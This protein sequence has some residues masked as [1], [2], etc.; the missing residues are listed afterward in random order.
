MRLYGQ[1]SELRLSL[2]GTAAGTPFTRQTLKALIE[3]FHRTHE[4]KRG[5]SDR[6]LVTCIH[7]L[8]VIAIGRNKKESLLQM[9][10]DTQDA[11]QALKRQRDVY[12]RE[13][14]GFVKTPCFR[15]ESLRFGN[16]IRGPAVIEE[17][18]ATIIIPPKTEVRVDKFGNYEGKL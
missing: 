7:N 16:V 11:S 2:S 17:K 9:R 13:H 12:F 18:A 8:N 1:A 4:E 15:G 10:R 14:G 5:Y 3:A 6:N